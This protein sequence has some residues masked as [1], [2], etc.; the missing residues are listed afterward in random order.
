MDNKILATCFTKSVE[1][2][3]G[4]TGY[5]GSNSHHYSGDAIKK[6]REIAKACKIKGVT[7]SRHTYSGGSSITIKVKL[8]P[9]DVRDYSE[10]AN[11]V[12]RTDFLNVNQRIWMSDPSIDR[13]NCNYLTEKFWTESPE[14]KKKLLAHWGN[15]WYKMMVNGNGSSIMHYWQLDQ[16]KN[17]CFTEQFFDR[18]NALGKIVSSFNYDHSNGQVDYFDVNFYEH[19]NIINNLEA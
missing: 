3:M 9:G 16:K 2:Y 6:M 8:M 14:T 10:I 7:F 19:W 18:W 5:E 13:P 4:A 1:A 11:Q 17:P 15:E 12:E